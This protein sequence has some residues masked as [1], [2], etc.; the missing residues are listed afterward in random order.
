MQIINVLRVVKTLNILP[1]HAR[2]RHAR[3]DDGA[4]R[5]KSFIVVATQ[6]TKQ[7]THGRALD[8]KTAVRLSVSQ[9]IFHFFIFF[10]FLNTMNI[11]AHTSVFLNH[12]NR[13][14]DMPDTTLTENVEFLNSQTLS[15]I[16]IPLRGQKTFWRHVESGITCYR[17]F[18]DQYTPSV[19]GTDIR[20]VENLLREVEDRARQRII[21]GDTMH[22]AEF[23][24]D[25]I[26]AKRHSGPKQRHMTIL[27]TAENIAMHLV[28]VFPRVIDVEIR[29]TAT[30]RIQKTLKIKVEAYW[31]Y[32]SDSQAVSHNAVG[33]AATPDMI[34]SF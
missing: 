3:T 17:I 19:Y 29:R 32:I 23:M 2:F 25:R 30:F 7:S 28:A 10:K 33:S 1:H 24:Q 13:V 20:E 9:Q 8:I 6:F 15:Y 34:N 18:S 21:F 16:H 14:F 12:L 5:N 22:L 26:F 4:R 11:N 27:I 31:V